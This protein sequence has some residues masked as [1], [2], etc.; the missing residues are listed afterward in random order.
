M[1]VGEAKPTPSLFEN[2]RLLS[3]DISCIR[4]RTA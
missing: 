3:L 1:G 2:L 4:G